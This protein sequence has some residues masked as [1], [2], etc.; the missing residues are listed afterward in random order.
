MLL[1]PVVISLAGCGGDDDGGINRTNF[2]GSSGTV[3]KQG[4]FQP[5]SG[6]KDRC[7]SPRSGTN[8]LRGTATDENN[9]LRSWTN[10]T[11]LWFSEVTDRNPAL[12][13]DPLEYFDTLK[14]QAT[15]TSG[16]AKDKFHFTYDTDDWQALSEGGI[17]SGYGATFE[18]LAP[19]PPRR[20]VVA[21]VEDG[22]PAFGELQRG[23][24]ILQVDGAD[25]VNGNTQADVDKLNGGLF[26]SDVNETHSFLVRAPNGQ[27]RTVTLRSG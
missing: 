19:T 12:Y 9:W 24:E 26:P 13:D 7:A 21:F 2:Q 3:W 20:I 16:Q 15:T 11:Y 23:D 1:F 18:I 22:E 10:D 14:T 25:A 27:Q 8:D 17:S 5:A 6:F 4:V